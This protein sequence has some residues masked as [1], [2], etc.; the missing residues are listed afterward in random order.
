VDSALYRLE[1][2]SEIRRVIRGIYDYPR[3]SKLLDQ[4]LI[5]ILTRLRRLC[6]VNS[7][8]EFSPGGHRTEFSRALHPSSARAVYLSDGQT[9]LTSR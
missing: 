8:G 4:N 1:K 3:F 6:R 5:L 2:R 7:V 9:G